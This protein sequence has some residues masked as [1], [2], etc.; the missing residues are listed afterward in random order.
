MKWHR[1]AGEFARV[2]QVKIIACGTSWH[3]GL[4]GQGAWQGICL[5]EHRAAPHRSSVL[6]HL[7]GE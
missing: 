7:I 4:A 6:L 5:F 1:A 3:A 2:R